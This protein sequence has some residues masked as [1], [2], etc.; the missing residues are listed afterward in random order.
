[1]AS[2]Q[3]DGETAVTTSGGGARSLG[4]ARSQ[5]LLVTLLG[6]FFDAARGPIPSAGLVRLLGEFDIAPANARAALSRLTHRGLLER[7]KQ[8]RRTSYAPTASA[9]RVLERGARRIF[10]PD[11]G[12]R[13]DGTWTLVAFSLPLDDGDLRRLLRARLRWLTFWP[14]FD[15]TWVTPHDR[16]DA[17]REQLRELEI[18]DALVL[19][20]R[21]LTLL[22]AGEARLERAWG[23]DELAAGYRRFLDTYA[24]LHDRAFAGDVDDADALVRR[25]ELVDDWRRLV[26][27]DPDLPLD[28]LPADF[29]RA[30]A[31]E[32]FLATYRAL[33]EGARARFEALVGS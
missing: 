8:G 13:W 20:T 10:A 14:A 4:R 12:A 33:S 2:R 6:D 25:T 26:R 22:P 24:E 23:L 27:D 15:A 17:V 19:R 3:A 21:E 29:P 30:Q 5:R 32:L 11:D 18:T 9:M 7:S 16:A 28:F 1:M 31:R